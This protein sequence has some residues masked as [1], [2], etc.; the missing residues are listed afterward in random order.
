MKNLGIQ[1][2]SIRDVINTE[3]EIKKTFSQLAEY[4][5]NEIEPYSFPVP[6]PK[7]AALA[8]E[9]GLTIINTHYDFDKVC[10]ETQET[11]EVHKTLGTK[12]IGTGGLCRLF[13]DKESLLAL[14]AKIN[15]KA[16]I[17]AKHGF[18][19]TYHN[20]STEFKKF[21][22]DTKTWYD[23]FIENINPKYVSLELD[24]Y[25]VQHGG[26]DVC[27]TLKRLANGKVDIVHLKDMAAHAY[28]DGENPLMTE[29]GNGNINFTDIIPLAQSLGVEHFIVEQDRNY[30]ISSMDSAKRSAKYLLENF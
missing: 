7:F 21:E 25:W 19:Y 14:I 15:E 18:K 4:G 11:I 10:N 17:F 30:K 29:C 16:E 9:A 8:K 28:E 1:L 23:Y 13:S 5:Y 6:I 3:E 12:Y 27:A 22:N 2:W 26:A 24:T 20:H